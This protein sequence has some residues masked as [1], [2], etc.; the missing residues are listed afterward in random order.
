MKYLESWM[1]VYK[2]DKICLISSMFITSLLSYIFK[3]DYKDISIEALTVVSVFIVVYTTSFSGLV[4][5]KLAKEMKE[6]QDK[7]IEEKTELG[8][9]RSY[10][11]CSFIFAIVTIIL[12]CVCEIINA[13][14]EKIQT[15]MWYIIYSMISYSLFMGNLCLAVI[16]NRF[17]MNRQLWNA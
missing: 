13:R 16:V 17:M 5:T 6:K 7:N 4:G 2:K 14:Y 8:V 11:N 9:L 1:V 10:Y 12:S 15:E 3:L